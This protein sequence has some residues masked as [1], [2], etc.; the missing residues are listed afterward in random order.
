MSKKRS[1]RAGCGSC[2]GAGVADV[3]CFAL[4]LSRGLAFLVRDSESG[5]SAEEMEL[6]RAG[7]G[8]LG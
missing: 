6:D 3:V 2:D 5:M 4:P 1:D 7:E 8:D